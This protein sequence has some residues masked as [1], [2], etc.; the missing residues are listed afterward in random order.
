MELQLRMVPATLLNGLG[1]DVQ[2]HTFESRPFGD[3][4][5][6]DRAV[7]AAYLEQFGGRSEEFADCLA[8]SAIA[9]GHDSGLTPIA[10]EPPLHRAVPSGGVAQPVLFV[11]PL[12]TLA[13]RGI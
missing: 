6:D 3:E 1:Q 9:L 10:S 5:G 8:E 12:G 7:A 2:A 11:D 4:S 13:H